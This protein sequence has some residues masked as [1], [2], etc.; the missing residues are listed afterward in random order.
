M[1]KILLALSFVMLL[2]APAFAASA[3]EKAVET[4][5]ESMRQAML[6]GNSAD[7]QKIAMPSLSYGHSAGAIEDSKQFVAAIAEKKDVYKKVEFNN[8]TVQV[9][10]DVAIVRHVFDGTVVSKGK[11]NDAPYDVHLG[12]MQIW[13]KAGGAWK[14]FARQAFKLPS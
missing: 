13:R 9:D 7:L 3:D 14:L 6:S 11:N 8:Q 10:G 1:K 4:A 2:A 12:V 5:V